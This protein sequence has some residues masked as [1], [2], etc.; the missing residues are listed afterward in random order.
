MM[1]R[2]RRGVTGAALAPMALFHLSNLYLA[3]LFA[4]VAIDPLL[5]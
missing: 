5:R 3:L 1:A 4:A 2:S